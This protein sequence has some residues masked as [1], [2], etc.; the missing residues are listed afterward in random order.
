[1]RFQRAQRRFVV[2]R[3]LP[4]AGQRSFVTCRRQPIA[5]IL[6]VRDWRLT[7]GRC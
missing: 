4:V 5:V 7:T 2:N 6:P 3:S 1:M